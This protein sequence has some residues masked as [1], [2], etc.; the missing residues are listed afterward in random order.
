MKILSRRSV[1]GVIAFFILTVSADAVSANLRTIQNLF[2]RKEYKTARI[3]LEKEING[4]SGR[5]LNEAK[6]LLA[7][8]QTAIEPAI[9]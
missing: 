6:L 5:T 1:K 4:F 2:N 8:L 9:T 7:R 3:Q